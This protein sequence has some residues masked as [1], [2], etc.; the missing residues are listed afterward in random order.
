L[1]SAIDNFSW[2][3]LMANAMPSACTTDAACPRVAANRSPLGYCRDCSVIA[4]GSM[5]ARLR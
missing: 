3:I 4:A 1:V 2:I 5:H